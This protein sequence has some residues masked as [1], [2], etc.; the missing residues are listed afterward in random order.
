MNIQK[1]QTATRPISC[2]IPTI[3]RGRKCVIILQMAESF[4]GL[5]VHQKLIPD[6]K[7]KS[8]PKIG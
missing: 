5:L 2:S 7:D 6:G 3:Q 1:N 4:L 8:N